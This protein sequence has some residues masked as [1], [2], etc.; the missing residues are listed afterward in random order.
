VEVRPR[1]PFN[2]RRP[3]IRVRGQ[4]QAA[5]TSVKAVPRQLT[6]CFV[7]RLDMNFTEE[8][9][10]SFLQSQGILDA[11]CHKLSPKKKHGPSQATSDHR[12][13]L[14][15]VSVVLSQ[16]PANTVIPRIRGEPVCSAAFAGTHCAYARRDG[17]AELT[18]VAGYTSR[19]FTRLQT[20]THPGTNRVRRS[21][22]MLIEIN[23]LPLSQIGQPYSTGT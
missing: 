18:W 5:S 10:T 8:E 13:V 23:A 11:L 14:I 6:N 22:T 15:S 20:A 17:Q 16:T 9:L 3:A 2:K 7:S 19:W 1:L 21:A 12:A 4:G